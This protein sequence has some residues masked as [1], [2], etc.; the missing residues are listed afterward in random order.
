MKKIIKLLFQGILLVAPLALTAYILVKIFN[1]LDTILPKN[2]TIY[3]SGSTKILVD[4]I[5]G[6]GIILLL[7]FLIFIGFLGNTF[8]SQPIIN[9]FNKLI[10]K[11]PLIKLIYDAVK[12][13]L[14]AFVGDKKKFNHPVM[15]KDNPNSTYYRI[16]FV[17]QESVKLLDHKQDFSAIY[18]PHSY[19]FSGTVFLV[20]NQHI[21]QLDAPAG[22]VMKFL[23]S[24]GVISFSQLNEMK[25]PEI[26][27]P[28]IKNI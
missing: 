2:M 18:F 26:K 6:L 22:E 17:T 9:Y 28:E 10:K 16:G 5:P 8:I 19:A 13:L 12:D 25:K 24:G 4:D 3:S 15:V 23:V 21:V 14:G 27:K 20:E 7:L 11:I 1:L